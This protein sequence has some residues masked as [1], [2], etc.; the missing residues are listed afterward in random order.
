MD[1]LPHAPP[2]I[3][4][5]RCASRPAR[6]A[7]IRA[8]SAAART[9][10][11]TCSKGLG[12]WLAANRNDREKWPD[13]LFFGGD[14]IYSDEIGDDHGAMLVQ[15][16][17]CGAHSGAGRSG[18]DGARQAGR[19]RLGGPFR[20]SLQGLHDAGQDAGRPRQGR[21]RRARPS[22]IAAT[23]RSR[24]STSAYAPLNDK[25]MREIRHRL[26]TGVGPGAGRQDQQA[27][28]LRPGTRAAGDRG[29]ALNT[30]S[31]SFRYFLPHWNA[32]LDPG[33]RRQPDG[34]PVPR[35]Q[36]PAVGPAVL[37]GASSA[38]R[39]QLEPG[40]RGGQ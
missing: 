35:A 24:T 14:Q 5:P 32:A 28:G 20:A 8:M 30:R 38:H 25:E 19:R 39:R 29:E 1:R 12:L 11:P 13:F 2:E 36:F 3:R 27:E 22:S 23:R 9:G 17:I 7:G 15:R 33:L 6:A 34:G 31:G 21:P 18:G 4:R 26:M 40:D 10:A 37:R 16:T